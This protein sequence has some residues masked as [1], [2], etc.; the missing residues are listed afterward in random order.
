MR[1]KS[2]KEGIRVWKKKKAAVRK[3]I[4]NLCKG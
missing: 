4:D 1:R 2:K 3:H